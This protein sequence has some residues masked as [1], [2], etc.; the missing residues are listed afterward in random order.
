LCYSYCTCLIKEHVC[1][2]LLPYMNGFFDWC[3]LSTE[4]MSTGENHGKKLRKICIFPKR[5]GKKLYSSQSIFLSKGE[6]IF[7]F[8]QKILILIK[9]PIFSKFSHDLSHCVCTLHN[10]YRYVIRRNIFDE[11]IVRIESLVCIR[12]PKKIKNLFYKSS[13]SIYFAVVN[14]SNTKKK[15]FPLLCSFSILGIKTG[16]GGTFSETN[17]WDTYYDGKIA[18]YF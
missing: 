5:L 15:A 10:M 6:M 4:K 16:S 13:L 12:V 14:V 8:W 2:S 18:Y 1:Y 9:I 17:F 7:I 3:L 11:E